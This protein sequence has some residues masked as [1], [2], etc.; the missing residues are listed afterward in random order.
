MQGWNKGPAIWFPHA[1][2]ARCTAEIAARGA[3]P[4]AHRQYGVAQLHLRM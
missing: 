3:G 4:L 2:R 1:G